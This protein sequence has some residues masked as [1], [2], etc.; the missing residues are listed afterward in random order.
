MGSKMTTRTTCWVRAAP[1]RGPVRRLAATLAAAA[2]VLLA[3]P[4]AGAADAELSDETTA[5]LK[6]HDKAGLD[7]PLGDGGTLS[8]HISTQGY[9]ASVHQAQ[10]CTDCHA[11]IDDETHG[12]VVAPLA[13][14]RVITEAMQETCRDCHKKKYTQYDD[15][16]HASLAKDGSDK[17]PL[18]A[19][20]HNAHTQA[21]VAQ[22]API[23]QTPCAACH[24]KIFEAWS[25]DVHGLKRAASG[26]A[27]PICA[28]CHQAHDV[29]AASLGD[30]PKEACLACHKNAVAQH[31][32]W[33]PNAGRHFEAISCPVCHAPTAQRRVNLRLYE[34]ATGNQLREKSGVP[35]FV[36]RAEADDEARAG[37][38]ERA[39]W[40]LLTQ[41]SED[42]DS[43][44]SVVVRGRL[45][46]RDGLQAHQM[47]DK[48]KALRDCATCHSPG[49]EAF[50][51][52]ELSIASADGR[53]LRHPV[54]KDV[55]SSL[56]ALQSVHGFYVIGSTRIR[57]LDVL[58]V[59][60]VAGSVA[61]C[62]THMAIRRLSKGMRERFLAEA[63]EAA[64]AQATAPVPA[65][66]P[67]PERQGDRGAD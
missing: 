14:R 54:Q 57:L 46:L 25:Q 23:D 40:S 42:E 19:D 59:L 15:S 62:L 56:A 8:L 51:S 36:R 16:I 22:L 37:L 5:C 39:L 48:T 29:K 4:A 30:G 33:L 2:L 1:H 24:A 38:D 13:S 17:A 45:E 65:Q 53:P 47:A 6:C 27:A 34:R 67:G 32:D 31:R 63:A 12:K 64:A 44:G 55:L 43:D 58:L 21:A 9:L 28:D 50:Q 35:Q 26:K 10:D 52:V 41:F 11:E 61:G 18:C 20:C 49:A 3:W 60:V 66:P 7:K